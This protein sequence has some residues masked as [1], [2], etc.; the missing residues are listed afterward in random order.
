APIQEATDL[1]LACPDAVADLTVAVIDRFSAGGTFLD[2]ALSYLPEDRWDRLVLSA[3][4]ALERASENEAACSVIAYAG[5]QAL[6]SLHTHLDRIFRLWPNAGTYYEHYPWR[7][8]GKSHLRILR[9]A[10]EDKASERDLR[11][12]AWH[13]MLQTRHP[14]VLGFALA[15]AEAI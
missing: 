11:L 7:E 3:L 6:P 9:A 10:I 8:S 4:D 2:A 15:D 12:H 1:A 14:E 5:L 13:A